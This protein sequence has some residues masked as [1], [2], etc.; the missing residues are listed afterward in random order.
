[1]PLNTVPEILRS[2]LLSVALQLIALGIDDLTT[3]DF[4]NKPS[5]ES[6]QAALDELELLGAIK[7]TKRDLSIPNGHT[8][9][10][11]G[12][13]TNGHHKHTNGQLLTN[14]HRTNGHAAHGA[15]KN[16]H[17]HS[18]DDDSDDDSAHSKKLKLSGQKY[19]L[20]E[21]GR[22]M[23]Q[24]PVDP[25]LSRC[26]I[27]AEQI[28]CSE[29]ILKLVSILSVENVFLGNSVGTG[30][31]KR[32]IAQMVRQKFVSPDGDHITLLNVYRAYAGNKNSKEWCKENFLDI[33]NLKLAV[34]ICKQLRDLCHRNNIQLINCH[35][36]TVKIRQALISGFF[37]NAAEYHKE[38]EY[39]TVNK[40]K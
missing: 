31:D 25:K 23:A 10:T 36:D 29:E 16:G 28:G 9:T 14:G 37:M 13:V 12:H 34:D 35:N 30:S 39:K 18:L 33:K 40:Y 20:T 38:N 2:N 17:K 27:A 1:M 19:E 26:L 32:E 7:K 24:F 6:L 15:L 22:K 11:N 4:I 21:I 8:S 5:A 3:F